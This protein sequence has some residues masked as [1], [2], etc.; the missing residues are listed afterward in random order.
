MK[1]DVQKVVAES[2]ETIKRNDDLVSSPVEIAITVPKRRE[3]GDF[4]T[5]IALILA[6]E[7]GKSPRE[8]A[9]LITKNISKE[10][11]NL[12]KKI[13]IAG[14]GFINFFIN[15][16]TIASKLT[17]IEILGEDFGRSNLG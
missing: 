3:F 17:E 6:G 7:L 4:S 13:E 2:I 9:E 11:K 16:R 5:N 15:E 14:P 12:F 8:V 1:E 10:G